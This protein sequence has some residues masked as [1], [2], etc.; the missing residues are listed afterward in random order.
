MKNIIFAVACICLAVSAAYAQKITQDKVPAAAV[1][2]FNKQFASATKTLWEMDEADFEVNFKTNGVEYSA[3]Y[4]KQGTWLETEQEIKLSEL[5][6][7]VKKGL[8]TEF[9]KAETEEVEKVSYPT[10][11]AVYE[12]EIEKDKQK[13]EVQFSAEGKLLKKEEIHKKENKD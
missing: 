1:S 8:E 5:P 11:E 12:M 6:A 10:G 2:N 3:K 9:P 4:D 13:F 7:S